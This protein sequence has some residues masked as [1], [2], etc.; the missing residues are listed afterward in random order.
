MLA[1]YPN[2]TILR[3]E[4]DPDGVYEAHLTTAAGEQVTVEVDGDFTVTRTE[5]LGGPGG[6]DGPPPGVE[7]PGDA[8]PSD[9]SATSG[10]S[11]T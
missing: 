3:I 1:D 8:P 5:A 2:A 4:T 11:S 7:A 6:H 10:D 9:G